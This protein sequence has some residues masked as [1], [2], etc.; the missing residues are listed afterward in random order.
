[1]EENYSD[2]MF[3]SIKNNTA[4]SVHIA[5]MAQFQHTYALTYS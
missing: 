4:D 5:V 2:R 1:M 3:R